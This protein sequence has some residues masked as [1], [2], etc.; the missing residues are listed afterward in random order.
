MYPNRLLPSCTR[1]STY[2][3]WGQ[4]PA[5]IRREGAC[6]LDPLTRA[7]LCVALCC[8]GRCRELFLMLVAAFAV[9]VV[10]HGEGLFPV[11]AEAAELSLFHKRHDHL[12]AAL[13]CLEQPRGV[14]DIAGEPLLAV[15]RAIK[16]DRAASA[17]GK[18]KH[19]TF[20][21]GRRQNGGQE[22]QERKDKT[23]D[24]DKDP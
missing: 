14:A 22:Q 6:S 11:V 24:A 15:L 20:G 7:L 21:D 16:G 3:R 9:G 1:Y 13:L 10:A 19:Q 8:T 18:R 23:T 2:I 4:G 5:A 17:A 12:V